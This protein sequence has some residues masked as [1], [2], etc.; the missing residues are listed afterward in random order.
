VAAYAWQVV[1]QYVEVKDFPGLTL[2][3]AIKIATH[4]LTQQGYTEIEP[5]PSQPTEAEDGLWRLTFR[6]APTLRP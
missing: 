1:A 2:D 3:D 5:L 4:R 6:V